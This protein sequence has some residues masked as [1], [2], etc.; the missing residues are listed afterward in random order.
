MSVAKSTVGFRVIVR[1][2]VRMGCFQAMSCALSLPEFRGTEQQPTGPEE[3]NPK[4]KDISCDKRDAGFIRVEEEIGVSAII[5]APD[6]G[7]Y[8]VEQGKDGP[9]KR[10]ISD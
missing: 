5:I 1:I 2:S 4:A 10:G 3:E 6:D 9:Q 7:V 8:R